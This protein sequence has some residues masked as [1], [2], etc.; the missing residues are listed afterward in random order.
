MNRLVAVG[1]VFL[2]TSSLNAG[3]ARRLKSDNEGNA[4]VEMAV[5]LPLLM[6]V[7]TGIF[8]YSM[9]LYQKLELAEAVSNA[10]RFLATARGYND[11]C[12]SAAAAMMSA[13]PSLSKSNISVTIVL[14]GNTDFGAGPV[15]SASCP[16]T[17]GSPNTDMVSG[18]T[19]EITATYPTGV[20]LFGSNYG[21]VDL[22]SAITEVVQ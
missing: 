18:G 15:T 6:L 5:T 9:A 17:G 21:S 16:G 20:A 12:Q 22:S 7:M 1:K 10:G 11:P 3:F 19:A 8:S 4:L 13:A 2:R 14:N